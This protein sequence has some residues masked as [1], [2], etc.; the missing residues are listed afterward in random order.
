MLA[1]KQCIKSRS[2]DKKELGNNVLI[3]N[4]TMCRKK[5]IE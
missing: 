2:V 5:L 4:N 1:N 3:Y